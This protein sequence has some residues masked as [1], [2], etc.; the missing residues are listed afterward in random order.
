MESV[1]PAA[2]AAVAASSSA[3]QRKRLVRLESRVLSPSSSEESALSRCEP[4]KQYS[5]P[6]AA[7]ELALCRCTAF[8]VAAN[9]G[10]GLVECQAATDLVRAYYGTDHAM[11][12]DAMRKM[13]MFYKHR[14]NLAAAIELEKRILATRE[15]TAGTETRAYARS[16]ME[17][18]ND[19]TN[20]ARYDEAAKVLE[21]ALAFL[22][23]QDQPP[24]MELGVAQL[25]VAEN[26]VALGRNDQ[27]IALAH[28]GFAMIERMRGATHGDVAKALMNYG[29][30]LNAAG[31]REE[32]LSAFRRGES[33]ATQMFGPESPVTIGF[34]S[35]QADVLMNIGRAKEAVAPARRAFE[36]AQ[37]IAG[38][39]DAAITEA[40]LGAALAKSGSVHEGRR[41]LLN[42]RTRFLSTGEQ[43]REG[44]QEAEHL[45]SI[46]GGIPKDKT[47]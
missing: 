1:L 35:M 39:N 31:R 45:L 33:L 24:S 32:A 40:V 11:A 27:G 37:R 47:R 43:G 8:F 18:G 30:T 28:S 15:R 9:A 38:P 14:S 3:S 4:L 19:L 7:I 20:A 44:L 25:Y 12:L 2:R 42:A 36:L 16:L 23:R 34:P 26:L 46:Y 41:H 17:L 22:Q 29:N 6:D 21:P 10:Q 5:S 13:T